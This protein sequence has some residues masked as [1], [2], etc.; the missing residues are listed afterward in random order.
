VSLRLSLLLGMRVRAS[1]PHARSRAPLAWLGWVVCAAV[2]SVLGASRP[3]LAIDRR[4][5]IDAKQAL[6]LALKEHSAGD[7]DAAALRLERAR[8]SCGSNRCTAATR[9][10]LLRDLGAVT[11]LR[12]DKAKA[13]NLFADALDLAPELAWNAPYDNK[14]VMAEWAAVHNERAALKETPPEG[15]FEHVPQREQA[16]D[17][18]LPIYAELNAT[19]VSKVVVKYK[20]P[21]E[22]EFKRRTLAR[23]GGGFGG[24]IPCQ[25][26]KRGL[27]RYFLQA[28]DDEGA[29]IANSGDVRHLYFV[30]IRWAI[31]GEPPHLPGQ[32]PPEACNGQPQNEEEV[33]EAAAG[34]KGVVTQRYVH[35]W[36]GVAGSL[37]FTTIPSGSNV[38]AL[39]SALTPVSSSFYCTNPD[40]SDFPT[41]VATGPQP[42][43]GKS[44]DSPGGI[45]SGN[46]RILATIDY[47]VNT[48]F[49]T[50]VRVGYVAQSYTGAAASKDGH[51]ISTPI[52]VELRE[53]YLFGDEPLAHA[54][55]APYVFLAGGYAKIDASELSSEELQGVQGPR[56]VTVWRM[57]GPFFA[58]VGGGARYA[59]SPRVAF[60]AG[61]KVALPFGAAGI[62]P[63]LAPEVSLQYGF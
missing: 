50:G 13:S 49:L 58:A 59:F 33:P 15:D 21:G 11:F 27:L 57:G 45:T 9:A 41:R 31:S 3:A 60:L 56:P 26:V 42:V 16:V 8:K 53:T 20:V 55:F 51:E 43:A 35:M 48:H 29:P 32:S 19:G 38:C 5:E 22:T 4:V 7:D 6:A 28:F 44:G 54:G 34:Q 47:A 36:I 62:L 10:A 18:P 61:L 52:H 23:F 1:H 39:T 30:P 37:D 63:T 25:D 12:G 2:L 40:G 17:T 24:T 14:D 46:V